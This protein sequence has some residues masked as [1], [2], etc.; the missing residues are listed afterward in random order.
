M[1]EHAARQKAVRSGAV[2]L[3][4]LGNRLDVRR[5]TEGP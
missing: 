2:T 5:K 1:A 4:G 3:R